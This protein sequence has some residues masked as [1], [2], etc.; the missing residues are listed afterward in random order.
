M[1]RSPN[2]SRDDGAILPLVLVVTVVLSLIVVGIATYTS[3][4]LRYGQV[5]EARAGRLASAQ[6]AM[7]DALEQLSLRSSLCATAAGGAG[8]D[9]PFPATVNDSEVIVSCRIVGG[10]LP[11]AD[12]W[13]IVIT[14]EGAPA[15]GNT[16]EFSLGGKPEINGP[17]FLNSPSRSLF[18][19]PTTI[20]E[21]DIWYPDDACATSNPSDSGV[22][23]ARSSMT[24]PNLTFDP[25]TRG[26]H[27][28]NREWDELFGTNLIVAPEVA[29]Y[30]NGANPTYLNPPYDVE[31]S[32]RV[33][34]PG[35]Y[36]N[37]PLGNDNYFKSGVYVFDN[38]G[39]VVLKGQTMTMGNI[40]RQEYP[41]V[42]NTACDTVR[43]DDSDLGATLYTRGNTR[44]ESQSNS[45]IEVSGRLQN[46]AWVAVHVLDSTLGYSTPLFTAN[47]GAKK[48]VALQGLLW[49]PYNSLQF[50][51]IPAQK[52][53][54]LRGGAV[55]AGF[56][57]GV[58]A[59]AVGFVIEVPTSAASTRLLLESTATDSMGAN[60][61]R[62]VADYRPSTGEVAVASRRVLD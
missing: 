45:G 60:T 47:T 58:S 15:T 29:T 14:E 24:L 46:T 37:L 61:V 20:V 53:A 18:S 13:A 49:A 2:T 3:A 19:Q 42:D 54:V 4:A 11:P 33:F 9:V 56:R 62:V 40:T 22:Q 38:V 59:A 50:E 35:Y 17:V 57:G 21:G 48:E 34:E 30:D 41:A 26:I 55:V 31:G 44:F 23:F 52:A 7:D 10:S 27:C 39:H 36:T 16:F 8:I 25:T 5:S 28:V 1:Q 6:G 43:L 12:G 32:C 51:T